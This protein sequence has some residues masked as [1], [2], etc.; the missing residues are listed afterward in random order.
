MALL[1]VVFSAPSIDLISNLTGE[2]IN[3]RPLTPEYRCCHLREPVRFVAGMQTLDRLGCEAYVEIGPHPVLL[4]L[5]RQCL[6]G[7]GALWLPSLRRN[8]PEWQQL[9][10]CA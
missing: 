3:D 2:L 1:G 6:S 5:G 9:L 7:D 8:R 10:E 4:G